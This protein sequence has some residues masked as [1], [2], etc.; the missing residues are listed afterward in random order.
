MIHL[1]LFRLFHPAEIDA[2]HRFDAVDVV[3]Q[4]LKINCDPFAPL[5]RGLLDFV[6]VRQT[7]DSTWSDSSLW[8]D[9]RIEFCTSRVHRTRI[10]FCAARISRARATP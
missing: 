4:A 9:S 2:F 1:R 6:K 10:G 7:E 3:A 5:D 8:T